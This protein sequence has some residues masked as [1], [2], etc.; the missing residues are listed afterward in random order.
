MSCR[1]TITEIETNRKFKLENKFNKYIIKIP[2]EF[3]EMTPNQ[4]NLLGCQITAFGHGLG[5]NSNYLIPKEKISEYL[6]HR[7][8]I[9]KNYKVD[10]DWQLENLTDYLEWL[11]N[12][13]KN[14]VDGKEYDCHPQNFDEF[15]ENNVKTHWKQRLEI[16]LMI[17]L[18]Q[19]VNS[20][21]IEHYEIKKEIEK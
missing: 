19:N 1:H 21:N 13:K 20:E 14:W 9:S 15:M 18:L 4:L 6:F 17:I 2:K 10:N 5:F 7:E 11:C 12:Y 3:L 8:R 16:F